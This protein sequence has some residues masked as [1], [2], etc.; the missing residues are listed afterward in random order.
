MKLSDF[1]PELKGWT[2]VDNSARQKPQFS[3]P[4]VIPSGSQATSLPLSL[5][6]QPDSLRQNNR[7]ALSSIRFAPLPP[8]GL[9]QINSASEGTAS[10]VVAPVAAQATA[11]QT[12]AEAAQAGVTALQA[13]SFQGTY[14][15]GISYSQGAS[16]D[17]A[18]II[19]VSLVNSNLGNT[20]A[21]SPSD[22]QSI[23]SDSGFLGVW[24]SA[25][26][27]PETGQVTASDGNYY[28][29]L[30]ANVNI[31]PVGNPAT[32]QLV[33]PKNLDAVASGS[34]NFPANASTLSYRCTTNPISATDS[35]GGHAAVA[36]A[37][38]NLQVSQKGLVAYSSGSITGLLNSTN[39]FIFTTDPSFSGGAVSY[40]AST[41][42][43][44]SLAGSG[45]I[46]IGSITTPAAGAISTIGN[47]DSGV[48][49]QSGSTLVVLSTAQSP[50]GTAGYGNVTPTSANTTV[51]NAGAATEQWLGY[52]PQ[53]PAGPSSITI[54]V[55]S[56]VTVTGAGV[57]NAILSYSTNGGSTFPNVIYNV[58]ANRALT[59]DQVNVTLPANVT[60]IVIQAQNSH[61]AGSG[62]SAHALS[63]IQ[64]VVQI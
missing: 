62:S 3:E 49:N 45:N 22:W 29:A 52:V 6:Y 60:S 58:S 36:I 43:T 61:T 23:G 9:P 13:T 39:Y 25:T 55:T 18:G 30:S 56:Q 54:S 31:N 51:S 28:I 12:T 4:S 5:Q 50:A 16:V 33:G 15:A 46:F 10:R 41:S 40:F 37:S 32:W 53:N 19:Y 27:Y 17:S 8:A 59:T 35:G 7:P 11:A 47:N 14:N 1:F 64:V 24:N 57:G 21:S 34:T 26:N 2:P 20:P 63:N 44:T 38:F 48:G 42:K